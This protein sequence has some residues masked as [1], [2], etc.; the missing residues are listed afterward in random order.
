M[1][2]RI[3]RSL[4]LEGNGSDFENTTELALSSSEVTIDPCNE[5]RIASNEFRGRVR[6]AKATSNSIVGAS[7]IILTA[8]LVSLAKGND[9]RINE[10]V[11]CS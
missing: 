9:P 7:W 2:I 5:G 11:P 4:R 10:V 8:L 3:T 1:K 6:L